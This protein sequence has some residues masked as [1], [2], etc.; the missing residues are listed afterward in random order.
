MQP[1][2]I[3]TPGYQSRS[4][5][6]DAQRMINWIPESS[7]GGKTLATLLPTPG[8]ELD[9][10]LGDGPIRGMF[11]FMGARITVSGDKVFSGATEIGTLST[12]TGPV[13][14]AQNTD[15]MVF[16]DGA[17][18][19]GWDG[20]TWA[21]LPDIG[22]ATHI[23]FIDQYFIFNDPTINGAFRHTNLASTIVD[24]LDVAT[25]EGSP[26]ALVGLMPDHRQLWLFGTESTEVFH[27]FGD[28][29]QVFQR[30]EGSFMEVGCAA[31]QSIVKADNAVGWLTQNKYGEGSFVLARGY[32]PQIVSTRAIE[33][34]WAKYS[35]I[36]DCESWSY[37]EDG[38][39]FVVLNFPT[40]Q[41]TWVFDLAIGLW[42]E[43]SSYQLNRH[44]A[45]CHVFHGGTHYVGDY[46]DGKIYEQSTLF[47]DDAGETVVRTRT[48]PY[49]SAN[50]ARAF[51]S[52]FELEFET[53]NAGATQAEPQAMLSWS[54]DNGRTYSTELWRG[55]GEQGRYT[56]RL[57]WNRLG[58]FRNRIFKVSISD[59]VRTTV[60]GAYGDTRI[61]TA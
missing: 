35:T 3:I 31:P 54:D 52:V 44:I 61:G 9:T 56:K 5:N 40:A 51:M 8:L 13:R 1:L 33:Y 30:I 32:Q 37:I 7:D 47:F 28:P 38:H 16:V 59:T 41:A 15:T 49:L 20:T 22:T 12:S 29:D 34:L 46:R 60:L 57:R 21:S 11:S 48:F 53:G 18:A 58:S 24:P 14:A 36:A 39:T 50:R 17:L 25:V 26:D 4:L 23:G 27:N 55:M 45:S 6:A 2:P 10:T 43:R 42:H 19:Y